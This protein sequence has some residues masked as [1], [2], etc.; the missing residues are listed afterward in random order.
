MSP[1]QVRELKVSEYKAFID[2]MN[3]TNQNQ[4]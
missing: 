3:E 4:G 1:A 2:F